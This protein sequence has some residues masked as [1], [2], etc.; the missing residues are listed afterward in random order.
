MP[1]AMV[2]LKGGKVQEG[3]VTPCGGCRQVL[4]EK[5]WQGKKPLELILYGASAIR[6]ISSAAHLLPMPFILRDIKD[7][8]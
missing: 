3:P 5:E 6:V 2:A 7:T 1:R 8:R 4:W